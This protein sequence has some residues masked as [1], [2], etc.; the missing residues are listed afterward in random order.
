MG[1]DAVKKHLANKYE[2]IG[3][4]GKGGFAEVYLARDKL[5]EREVAVKILL[6]Q[7]A[8]EPVTVER[9]IREARLYARLEHRNLIPVYDTGIVGKDAFIIMKYIKGESLKA[10]KEREGKVS[11]E[12]IGPIIREMSG[13]MGYIHSR[14]IIHR[15]IKPANILIEERTGIMY[16]A[17]FGIARSDMSKT[18]TQS[19][20]IV[21]TPNYI[22]PEQVKGKH[23]DNR[24]DIYAFGAMLYESIS[25]KPI[26]TG[27]SSIEILYQHVNEEP[28]PLSELV[29]HIPREI[30]YIVARCLEKDPDKR[31]QGA[32]EML[33]ILDNKRATFISRYLLSRE[34]RGKK[35]KGEKRN[36]LAAAVSLVIVVAIA[37]AMVLWLNK[38]NGL[39]KEKSDSP[40]ITSSAVDSQKEAVTKVKE[41]EE[42]PKPQGQK[43]NEDVQ[44]EKAITIKKPAKEAIEI[45]VKKKEQKQ[46]PVIK[47]DG[48]VRF[49]SYPIYLN[50]EV[51]WN[52][53]KLGD[54]TQAFEKPFKPGRYTFVFKIPG[55]REIKKE[56]AVQAG[57]EARAHVK[58]EPYGI[59]TITA[60]PVARFFINGEDYGTDYLLEKK[61]PVGEYTVKAVK[62][63][64]KTQERK[65]KLA[66]RKK[67]VIINLNFEK[68][69]TN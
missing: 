36:I 56:V 69:R 64:Y 16:L 65:M 41:I 26:F 8:D 37:V 40:I 47:A 7:F 24:A 33:A 55:Y 63:G 29:P 30:K 60:R 51:Y 2:F 6:S 66:W 45:P 22:S 67:P 15:D 13:T 5:L 44:K 43:E 25:G 58:F 49:S 20:L 50:T 62:K 11:M 4:I 35:G 21:G 31:F 28:K 12:S 23:I 9:F 34:S 17:D 42:L 68:R 1:I 59:V 10:L 38:D 53:I 57:K 18:L 27:D 39:D 14:G 19:G 32:G 46:P 3:L 52:D 54:T 61:L 48:I